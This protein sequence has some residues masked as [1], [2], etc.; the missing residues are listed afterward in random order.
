MSEEKLNELKEKVTG[1]QKELKELNNVEN[2]SENKRI[3]HLQFCSDAGK[4]R[5]R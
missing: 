4:N 5:S 3:L 2:S 1:L